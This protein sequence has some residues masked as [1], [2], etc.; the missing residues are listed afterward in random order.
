VCLKNNKRCTN[1]I[2]TKLRG[3]SVYEANIIGWTKLP[4][5]VPSNTNTNI[6]TNVRAHVCVCVCVCVRARAQACMED[7][8]VGLR[9][10]EY[11]N[12]CPY[13]SLNAAFSPLCWLLKLNITIISYYS[14]SSNSN[15]IVHV[16]SE[17]RFR[18]IFDFQ[19]APVHKSKSLQL[20]YGCCLLCW[21]HVNYECYKKMRKESGG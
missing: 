20:F 7:P 8:K 13:L 18:S 3:T 16:T 5:S 9:T 4:P 1:R 10:R 12:D 2:I 21:K 11:G 14:K 15:N 17:K 6:I 19:F